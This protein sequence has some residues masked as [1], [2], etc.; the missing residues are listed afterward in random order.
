MTFYLLQVWE[1]CS[2]CCLKWTVRLLNSSVRGFPTILLILNYNGHIGHI[3]KVTVRMKVVSCIIFLKRFYCHCLNSLLFNF[4]QILLSFLFTSSFQ[5][6]IIFKSTS[7]RK[8]F[9][10]FLLLFEVVLFKLIV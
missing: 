1:S 10:T 7:N 3:G 6:L 8:I 5:L 4:V 9:V 2:I